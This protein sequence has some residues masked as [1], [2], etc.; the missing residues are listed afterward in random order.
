MYGSVSF[1]EELLRSLLLPDF[2]PRRI[3]SLRLCGSENLLQ[4][5]EISTLVDN[6][7]IW[8]KLQHL[9][10]PK[11]PQYFRGE[12]S[13]ANPGQAPSPHNKK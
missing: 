6:R 2:S 5:V 3:R 4:K 11:L 12:T 7:A 10:R 9:S 8:S 13:A 1:R